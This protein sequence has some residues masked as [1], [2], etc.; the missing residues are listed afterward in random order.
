MPAARTKSVGF[1]FFKICISNYT[2][3]IFTFIRI[4][5]FSDM[6]FKL[7]IC[8]GSVE[9]AVNAQFAGADR[10]ELAYRMSVTFHRAFDVCNRCRRISPDSSKD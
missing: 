8:S 1:M 4:I 9:S 3:N 5:K 7:E 2:E 6:K 10:V